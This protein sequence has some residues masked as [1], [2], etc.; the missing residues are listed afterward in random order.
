MDLTAVVAVNLLSFFFFG[1]FK[2]NHIREGA[3]GVFWDW[4]GGF[5]GQDAYFSVPSPSFCG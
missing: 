5:A 1:T 2:F 3:T 4:L